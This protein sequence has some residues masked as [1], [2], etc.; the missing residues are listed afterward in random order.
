MKHFLLATAMF[1]GLISFAQKEDKILFKEATVETDDYKVYI[2]DAVS[3]EGE[4]KFKMKVFNKTNDYLLVKAS[5]IILEADGKT[6]TNKEDNLVIGPN[7]EDYRV[8]N[9]KGSGKYEKFS[10]DFKGIYKA[11]AG[12]KVLSA[13]DFDLPPTKNDVEAGGFSCTLKKHDANTDRAVAKF[14]CEYK[15]DGV[16]IINPYK[17]AA[18]M[19]NGSENANAKKNKAKVL[20]K[21]QK[22][23]FILQFEERVGAGDLQKKSIKVKWNDTFRESKL[24]ALAGSKIEML[25]DQEKMDS[26]K[27]KK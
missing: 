15:G 22:D 24:M 6:F 7:D 14:E 2:V 8:V 16:G 9:F 17:S 18:I 21:G 3:T 10:L 20:E 23:E 19:P 26:K 27:K 11:S 1:A 5:E 12:G 13:P 4:T 25:K